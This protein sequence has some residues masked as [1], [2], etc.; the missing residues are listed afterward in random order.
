M[1]PD[2]CW[3]IKTQVTSLYLLR[4]AQRR[5]ACG[6]VAQVNSCCHQCLL[7]IVLCMDAGVAKGTLADVATQWKEH[8]LESPPLELSIHL[9]TLPLRL[10]PASLWPPG[11][12][13]GVSIDPIFHFPLAQADSY[14]HHAPSSCF[15]YIGNGLNKTEFHVP[16]SPLAGGE[17][18][19][20]QTLSTFPLPEADTCARVWG[21]GGPAPL[22]RCSLLTPISNL[23]RP[24]L[25]CKVVSL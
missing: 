16:S 25:S 19:R 12:H 2:F 8:C 18:G 23:P 6:S 14:V 17:E 22:Y 15:H 20:G 5:Q 4:L 7:T 21:L 1:Y 13:F 11:F 3:A 10:L 9:C 24:D